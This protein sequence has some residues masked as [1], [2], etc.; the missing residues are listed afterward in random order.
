M[1]EIW[2][3]FLTP[4]TFDA[5]WFRSGVIYRKSK[6]ST[7]MTIVD[8]HSFS[9]TLPISPNFYWGRIIRNLA[10]QIFAHPFSLL[11]FEQVKK[12]DI[13][14]T[15]SSQSRLRF[16]DFETKHH[17]WNLKVRWEQQLLYIS[18]RFN[19]QVVPQI[20]ELLSTNLPHH[21]EKTSGKIR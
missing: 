21:T 5:L 14:P 19:V 7:Y 18:S 20:W 16:S 11:F 15:F 4:V 6:I 17:T 9:D 12:W 10:S 2:F 1:C 3:E 13:C 8:L